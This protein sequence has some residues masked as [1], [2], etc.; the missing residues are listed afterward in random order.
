MYAKQ[1]IDATKKVKSAD[2][3]TVLKEMTDIT[4]G[5]ATGALIGGGI[6]LF[7]GYGRGHNLILSAVIG[8][9]IGGAISR[10]FI[11]KN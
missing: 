5:T 6:G 10:A 9:I 7:I 2:G 8:S 11:V 4:K 1:F 3:T